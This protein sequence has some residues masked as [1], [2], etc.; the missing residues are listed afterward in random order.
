MVIYKHYDQ[1]QLNN[2]YNNRLHVPDYTTYFDRWE[3]LNIETRNSYPFIKDIPYGDNARERLDVFP[4]VGPNA[5]TLVYIHGGYWQMFDKTDFHFI[6]NAFRLYGVTTVLINYPL[7]PAATMDDIVACCRKAILWLQKNLPELNVG[8]HEIYIAGHSAGAHLAAMIIEKEWAQN[9]AANF[10]KG[11]C[12]L[13]GVFNLLPV[14]LSN[15]NT[16]INM[17]KEMAQRN[18]AVHLTPFTACPVLIYVGADETKEFKAQSSEL[19][20]NWKKKN[21]STSFLQLPGTNHFSI[22]ETLL[23][24]ESPV[25]IAMRKMMGI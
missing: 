1:Q 25:H 6:A 22:P 2:Q 8:S 23:N 11:V 9:N 15:L 7:A 19:Y 18:S 10:I 17:S 14:Q 3:K 24:K 4:S 21:S 20:N 16:V 12:L 5:K 13:S